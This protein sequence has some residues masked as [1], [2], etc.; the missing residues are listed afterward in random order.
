MMTNQ[1]GTYSVPNNVRSEI[2]GIFDDLRRKQRRDNVRR[3]LFFVTV[4][5][6]SISIA[7]GTE[8]LSVITIISASVSLCLWLAW[9]GDALS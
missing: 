6:F 5:S 9:R 4:F 8:W 7:T 1:P 2:K 3:L